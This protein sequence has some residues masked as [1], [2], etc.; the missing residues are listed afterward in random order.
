MTYVLVVL[1][2]AGDSFVVCTFVHNLFPKKA[3]DV[4]STH[5][6]HRFDWYL[7]L[8]VSSFIF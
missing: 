3:E 1:E 7:G 4:V 5:H 8:P 2:R 6:S